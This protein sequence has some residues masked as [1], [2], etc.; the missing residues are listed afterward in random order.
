MLS[1]CATT[2]RVWVG[3]ALNLDAMKNRLWF[4]LRNGVHPERTLQEAW[5]AQGEEAFRYEVLE[6]LDEDT[7]T[8]AISDLLKEKSL[9]WTARLGAHRADF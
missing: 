7:P 2:G 4:C 5:L 6:S 8:L 3:S 1:R 9:D